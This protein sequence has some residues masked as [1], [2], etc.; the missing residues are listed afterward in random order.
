MKRILLVITTLCALLLLSCNED[1]TLFPDKYNRILS[2][3]NS[4]VRELRSGNTVKEYKDS[5]LV[6]KGGGN[7]DNDAFARIEVMELGKA[8]ETF[9]YESGSIE[10]IASE[11]YSI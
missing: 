8:C 4:G 11:S 1:Y 2:L 6:L 10:I 9:G 3:K 5:I 7:P